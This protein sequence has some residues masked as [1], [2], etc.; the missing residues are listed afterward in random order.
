MVGEADAKMM[1]THQGPR[2]AY[3]VQTAVDSEHCLILHHEVTGH[4]TDNQQ[5]RPMAATVRRFSSKRR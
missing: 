3:N 5:L 4:G 2:V 1:C